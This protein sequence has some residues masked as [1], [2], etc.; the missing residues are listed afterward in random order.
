MINLFQT[1]PYEK[2][3]NLIPKKSWHAS[4]GKTDPD[5]LVNYHQGDLRL[6]RLNLDEEEPVI[7]E[8]GEHIHLYLIDGDLHVENEIYSENTDGSTG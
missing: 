6:E 7:T 3:I 4:Q 8:K 5:F 1:L 2:I